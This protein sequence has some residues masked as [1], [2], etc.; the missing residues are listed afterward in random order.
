MCYA[1]VYSFN[2]QKVSPID[3]RPIRVSDHSWPHAPRVCRLEKSPSP[4]YFF[5]VSL[6]PKNIC[7][8]FLLMSPNSYSSFP[9]KL[10]TAFFVMS[11]N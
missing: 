11:P 10:E 6:L 7:P 1:R 4:F 3:S 9:V 5:F 8:S 2:A